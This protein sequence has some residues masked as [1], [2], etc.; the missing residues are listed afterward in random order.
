MFGSDVNLSTISLMMLISAGSDF[1][2]ILLGIGSDSELLDG[3]SLIRCSTWSGMIYLRYHSFGR[4]CLVDSGNFP[5]LASVLSLIMVLR[6]CGQFCWW[7]IYWN[8]L[9]VEHLSWL[10]VEA[11]CC[12]FQEVGWIF[13]R[14]PCSLLCFQFIVSRK[15]LL[16]AE[17]KRLDTVLFCL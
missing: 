13:Y 5:V 10:V 8:L 16:S 12:S 17:S 4:F 9:P 11:D 14:L 3:A 6:C 7:R 1:L 15:N 2:R